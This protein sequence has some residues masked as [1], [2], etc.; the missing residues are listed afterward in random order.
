MR[1][2]LGPL[3]DLGVFFASS[4]LG[5]SSTQAQL[6]S[7]VLAAALVYLPRASRLGLGNARATSS[8]TGMLVHILA[9]TL[10]AL[11]L[12][13]GVFALFVG[14]GAPWQAAIVVAVLATA[15]VLAPAYKYAL[16]RAQSTRGSDVDWRAG[17]IGIVAIAGAY[18]VVYSGQVELLPE[19]TYYWNYSRHLDIGYL[20]HPP[21]VAW[22][23]RGGTALFGNTG[24]GVRVVALFAGVVASVF[25]YRLTRNLFGGASAL[26]AVALMQALPFFFLTGMLTTPDAPL[27]AA[28]IAALY[29]LERALI[30]GR[31]AAWWSAGVCLGLGLL[32][33]YTIALLAASTLVFMLSDSASRRWLVRAEPYG[34]ALIALTIFS[35]VIV[36]NARHDWASFAF[37]TSRRLA[38]AP[39]FAFHKLVGSILVL[40]T[41]V[42]FA[43]AFDLARASPKPMTGDE[44]LEMPRG[45]RFIQITILVPLVVFTAFSLR[46]EVKL[47]WTGAPFTALIPVL[48]YGIV[49]SGRVMLHGF[50]AW[51]RVSWG[52]MVLILLV[53]YGAGL[54]HLAVGIPGWGYGKH[55]ELVP[56]G[57]RELGAEVRRI[58]TDVAAREGRAPLIVGMDRYA[59]AS[60][61]AFY[62]G[63]PLQSVA[64]SS[65]AHLFGQVGLMY[66]RWFPVQAQRGRTLILV[67]WDPR[68]L[69]GP[70]LESRVERLGELQQGVL[71]R[72]AG[73]L[74][75]RYYYR[76]AYGYRGVTGSD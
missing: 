33:K 37:Q 11:F 18:R 23:I 53:A 34:A 62:G 12:R 15:A 49:R 27:T 40:L 63:D 47:D 69:A 45:W 14:W 25:S 3:A 65:S 66:E 67:A 43:S 17:A 35:P 64:D 26:V 16:A 8:P 52:P 2:L 22:L 74:V 30:A 55:P 75:R 5:A 19:E 42:G 32:S 38:S 50:R 28:W 73:D 76:L 36:W 31:A 21:M 41:P 6:V 29:F 44:S 46:H 71:R 7:F 10:L 39:R 60:E 72:T 61:L 13:L 54:Y 4:G 48:A 56:V 58:A 24:F 51:L 9:V 20:D 68:E 57:W 59:I 1:R 70:E